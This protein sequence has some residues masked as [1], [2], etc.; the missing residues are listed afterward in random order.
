MCA[1]FSA[2]QHAAAIPAGPAPTTSTSKLR[3]ELLIRSNVHCLRASYLAGPAMAFSV[4]RYPALEAHAH[5]AQ[6]AARL[7]AHGTPKICRAT[8]E[9]CRQRGHVFRHANLRAIHRH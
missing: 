9:N 5:S 7:A 3:R 4:Y 1:P 8:Q 6:R 2:A